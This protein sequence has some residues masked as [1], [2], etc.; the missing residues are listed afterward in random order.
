MDGDTIDASGVSGSITLL[1]GELLVSQS[2]T[3]LGPGPG[4]LAVSGNFTSRVLHI[5]N[6][7][8]VVISGL[9]ITEGAVSGSYPGYL[10]AGIWNDHSTLTLSSAW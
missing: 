2:I 5:S 4:S 6:G 8:T 10:G 9:T 1:S 7:A 3:L